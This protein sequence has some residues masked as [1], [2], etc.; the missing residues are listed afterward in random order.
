MHFSVSGALEHNSAI[1]KGYLIA[2]R[3]TALTDGFIGPVG[4]AIIDGCYF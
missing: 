3:E 1:E 2:L 4:V